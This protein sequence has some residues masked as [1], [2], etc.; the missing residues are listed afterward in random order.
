MPGVILSELRKPRSQQTHS[1]TFRRRVRRLGAVHDVSAPCTTSRRRA[2][3]LGAVHAVVA[4][5]RRPRAATLYTRA[6]ARTTP[7]MVHYP[8][9]CV[10][11]QLSL[12]CICVNRNPHRCLIKL[13]K[14]NLTRTK[15]AQY[16]GFFNNEYVTYS[17]MNMSQIKYLSPIKYLLASM[18]LSERSTDNTL[19]R[20]NQVFVW[21]INWQYFGITYLRSKDN[22][23]FVW[24]I[25][26]Q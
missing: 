16:F 1:T 13:I 19:A 3:R 5:A 2:R 25:K 21:K 15:V 20:A 24:K 26:W 12:N 7:G 22:K 23:V 8:A 18:S 6:R 17:I 14:L 4:P 10:T 11:D 9:N